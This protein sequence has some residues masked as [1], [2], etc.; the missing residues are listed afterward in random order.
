M[1]TRR[2]LLLAFLVFAGP[3]A[4]EDWR[5]LSGAEIRVVLTGATVS[6]D[7]D[8]QVFFETGRTRYRLL[9]DRWGWWEIRG[10]SY[11]SLWPPGEDWTC[12]AVERRGGR[13]RFIDPDGVITEATLSE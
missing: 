13:L 1:V 9:R 6:Y 4:A 11:C 12:F 5:A 7:P 3:A 10:D 8:T 2:S